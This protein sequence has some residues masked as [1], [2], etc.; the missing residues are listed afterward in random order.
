MAEFTEEEEEEEEEEDEDEE[1]E[2]GTFRVVHL[3]FLRSFVL[4]IYIYK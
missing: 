1:L 2:E 3:G 4:Y